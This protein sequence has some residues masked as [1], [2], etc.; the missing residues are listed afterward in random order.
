MK[1]LCVHGHFY[2]PPRENPFTGLI[3]QEVGAEP[4]H[5][6]NERITFECY[7]PAARLG[8]F[9][10][11]SFNVGPT[12]AAWLEAANPAVY[13]LIIK[14]DRLNLERHGVGNAIAQVYN[15]TILPLANYRDKITQIEWGLADFRHRFG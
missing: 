2:Q 8:L 13:E 14:A 10:R 5:N 3:P 15:H 11:M 7:E 6:W 1:Y 9:E 4:F 12:L